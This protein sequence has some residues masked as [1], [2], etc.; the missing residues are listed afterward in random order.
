MKEQYKYIHQTLLEWCLF[1]YSSVDL[2]DRDY[3]DTLLQCHKMKIENE[4]RVGF[5]HLVTLY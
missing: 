4:F 5:Y 2:D 1:G 3:L